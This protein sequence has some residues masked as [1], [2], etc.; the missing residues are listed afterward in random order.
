MSGETTPLRILQRKE[1]DMTKEENKRMHRRFYEEVVNRKC[2]DALD[3]LVA[4][5]YVSHALPARS[6][7]RQ[8]LRTLICSFLAAFPDARVSVDDQV[9]D[10]DQVIARLTFR[11]TQMAQFHGIPPLGQPVT[12]QIVE[13]ARFQDGRCI[14]RWGGLDQFSFWQQLGNVRPPANIPLQRTMSAAP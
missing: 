12:V 14:E 8:G 11:G 7:G 1:V 4:A 3:D 9:A 10:G 6:S 2:L 13:I 5:S